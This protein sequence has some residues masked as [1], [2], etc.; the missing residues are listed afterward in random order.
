MTSKPLSD[1]DIER[2]KQQFSFRGEVG[3]LFKRG[4]SFTIANLIHTIPLALTELQSLRAVGEWRSDM[5][6]APQEGNDEFLVGKTDDDGSWVSVVIYPAQTIWVVKEH[7]FTKWKPI[8]PP[9]ATNTDIL[10][11]MRADKDEAYRQR[12]HLVAALAIL[13]PSGTK[14]T[15]IEGWSDDWHGCVYI[16]LPGGQVSYHYHDSQAHLFEN[17]PPYTGE[18]DGHDKDAVHE[19]LTGLN[20]SMRE[21]EAR[22]VEAL[23]WYA[24]N[25]RY[26]YDESS[27]FG[28]YM[29]K[30]RCKE[31]GHGVLEDGGAIATS[32]LSDSEGS[33]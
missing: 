8:T 22:L 11:E 30:K 28:T 10:A 33:S 4:R 19:R 31:L 25:D 24:E 20:I 21:R 3:K 1:G 27:C 14:R 15:S 6:N 32:A 7:K 13:F 9:D 16:D 12:N 18:Y 23:E 29:T 26:E 5:E 2:I 17:L